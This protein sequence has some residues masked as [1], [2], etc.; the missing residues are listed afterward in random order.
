[1]PS[2]FFNSLMFALTVKMIK[3]HLGATLGGIKQASE[4]KL[5]CGYV[6]SCRTLALK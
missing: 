6:L 4:I 5:H 2:A 1:M 3:D